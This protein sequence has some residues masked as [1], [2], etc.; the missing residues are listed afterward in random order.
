MRISDW[1]SDVCSSD[2]IFRF[3]FLVD[4]DGVALAEGAAPRI[5]SREAHLL[6]FAEQGAEGEALGGRPV[7]HLAILLVGENRAA[8]VDHAAQRL[9]G[10]ALDGGGRHREAERSYTTLSDARR[11]S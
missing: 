2:L 9:V 10:P 4:P 11:D 7:E 1:S 3:G 8:R 5:L 6:A